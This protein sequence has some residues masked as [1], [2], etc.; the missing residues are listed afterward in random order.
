MSRA[1]TGGVPYDLVPVAS[2]DALARARPQGEA[3][4]AVFGEGDHPAAYVYARPGAGP[5]RF[6]AR[7]F[8]PGLGI[9]EDPATGSAVAASRAR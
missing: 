4:D 9:A 8:A 2:L 5:R 6:R 3:F 7:M 1:A